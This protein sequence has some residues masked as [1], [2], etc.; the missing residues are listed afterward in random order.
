[1]TIRIKFLLATSMML[2]ALQLQAGLLNS[3]PPA[4]AGGASQVA[5]R[6]GPI[7]FSP[8]LYDTVVTCTNHDAVRVAVGL[9]LFDERDAPAGSAFATDVAPEGIVTFATSNTPGKENLIVLLNVP[10]LEHGK[11]RIV[12]TTAKLSCAA[13]HRIHSADGTIDEQ[14]LGFI[15]RISNPPRN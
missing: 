11:G 15:K 7:Y 4:L 12:A 9:E 6:L 1:M 8:N 3:P 13:Y 2:F 14:A 10:P 5:Y